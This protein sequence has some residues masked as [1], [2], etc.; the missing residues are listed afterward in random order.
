[1]EFLVNSVSAKLPQ[2]QGPLMVRI[3]RLIWIK[4]A[5]RSVPIYAMMAENMPPWVCEEIDKICRKFLWVG[6]NGDV[7]GKCMVAWQ[8]MCSV[9]M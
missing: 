4:S 5:L 3:G 9:A 1:M 7:R 8:T 2:W 6:K